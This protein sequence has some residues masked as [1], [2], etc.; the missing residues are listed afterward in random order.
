MSRDA[1]SNADA[2]WVP[3]PGHTSGAPT[4]EY[5]V[6]RSVAPR[7][8]ELQPHLPLMGQVDPFLRHRRS[9]R[10]ATYPLEPTTLSSRHHEPACRSKP[11]ARA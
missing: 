3:A 5:D 11:F 1:S 10:V 6:R 8:A 7:L 2:P 9:Q 4:V